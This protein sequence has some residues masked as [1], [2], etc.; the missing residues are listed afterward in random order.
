MFAMWKQQVGHAPPPLSGSLDFVWSGFQSN[1]HWKGLKQ[2][3][4]AQKVSQALPPLQKLSKELHLDRMGK[5]GIEAFGL[6]RFWFRVGG[7]F[8]QKRVLQSCL[9]RLDQFL[10]G[11]LPAAESSKKDEGLDLNLFTYKMR[12]QFHSSSDAPLNRINR[13][14][15]HIFPETELASINKVHIFIWG[16]TFDSEIG[17]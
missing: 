3:V 11:A 15:Y 6:A 7:V 8:A 17:G 2:C 10:L 9:W 14:V 13:L 4:G 1:S 12:I 16:H 5:W